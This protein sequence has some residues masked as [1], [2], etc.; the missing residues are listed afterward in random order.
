MPE[1]SGYG[2]PTAVYQKPIESKGVDSD[3]R[4]EN[5]RPISRMEGSKGVEVI[6]S[7]DQAR[8]DVETYEDLNKPTPSRLSPAEQREIVDVESEQRKGNSDNPDPAEMSEREERAL[9]SLL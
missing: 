6:L 4:S 9:N 7:S 3:Q 5:S 2:A 1:V 8:V